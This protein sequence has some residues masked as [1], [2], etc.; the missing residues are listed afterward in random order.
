MAGGTIYGCAAKGSLFLQYIATTW[1]FNFTF[2]LSVKT[3]RYILIKTNVM[4]RIIIWHLLTIKNK[5]VYG[6]K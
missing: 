6:S 3:L 5:D 1:Q 4:K 2:I